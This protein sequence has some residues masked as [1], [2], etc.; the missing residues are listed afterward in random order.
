MCV[1]SMGRL[2]EEAQTWSNPPPP[3]ASGCSH[4]RG[5]NAALKMQLFFTLSLSC[6]CTTRSCTAQGC[7][8]VNTFMSSFLFSLLP[9]TPTVLLSCD[10]SPS[11]DFL[12]RSPLKWPTSFRDSTSPRSSALW[13]PSTKPLKV[14]GLASHTLFF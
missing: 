10:L 12:P 7:G 13:S 1:C 8:N 14:G 11:I 9:N 4:R 2:Q 6:V 5:V 3:P